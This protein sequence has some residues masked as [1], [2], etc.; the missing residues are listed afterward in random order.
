MR[1]RRCCA[2]LAVALLAGAFEAACDDLAELPDLAAVKPFVLQRDGA[3]QVVADLS[4]AWAQVSRL[5]GPDARKRF[6][7][8]VAVML[9]KRDGIAKFPSS[10]SCVV[11]LVKVVEYDSYNR[12]MLATARE[13]AKGSVPAAGLPAELTLEAVRRAAASVTLTFA[14]EN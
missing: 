13:L 5:R 4:P 6:L 3:C 10:P 2:A 11:K 1:A 14:P 12:P 7:T 9:V 8:A